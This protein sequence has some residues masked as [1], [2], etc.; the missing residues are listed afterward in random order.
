MRADLLA[1]RPSALLFFI[2]VAIVSLSGLAHTSACSSFP[3]VL[4]PRFRPTLRTGSRDPRIKSR[5][6]DTKT[7]SSLPQLP[8]RYL[9]PITT[10]YRTLGIEL[11]FTRELWRRRRHL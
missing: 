10:F 6:P 9:Y 5:D 11:A 7:I 8:V 2:L 3:S 1:P 4:I